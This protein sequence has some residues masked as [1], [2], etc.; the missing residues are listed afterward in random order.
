M[1]SDTIVHDLVMI[2][3]PDRVS[4]TLALDLDADHAVVRFEP[5]RRRGRNEFRI[6]Y[7]GD[8]IPRRAAVV[9]LVLRDKAAGDVE[10][11]HRLLG[12][13]RIDHQRNRGKQ[14]QA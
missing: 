8:P 14:K 2:E 1:L 3:D 5:I 13:H 4:A 6:A 7:R 9:D 12:L 10:A 11:V